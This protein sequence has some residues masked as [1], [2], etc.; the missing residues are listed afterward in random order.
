MNFRHPATVYYSRRT[1]VIWTVSAAALVAATAGAVFFVTGKKHA[2]EIASLRKNV[3]GL[4]R[5]SAK[6]R[7]ANERLADRVAALKRQVKGASPKPKA[8]PLP[9]LVIEERPFPV[10]E[11]VAVLPDR[12]FITVSRVDGDRARIRTAE[13]LSGGTKNTSRILQPGQTWKIS[14]GTDSFALLFHSLKGGEVRLSIR[15]L[16]KAK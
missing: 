13:I 1:L 15:R 12:L 10:G 3:Q 2:G 7:A 4:A 11:A 6:L 8:L 9:A 16:R 5:D 14:A